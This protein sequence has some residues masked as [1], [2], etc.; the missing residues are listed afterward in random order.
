[1]ECFN[2]HKFNSYKGNEYLFSMVLFMIDNEDFV[3]R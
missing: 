2:F 3:F 1:M